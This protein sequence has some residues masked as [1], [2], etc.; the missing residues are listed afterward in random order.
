MSDVIV[1]EFQ[2]ADAEA[3][4][5]LNREW[6]QRHFWLEPADLEVL[7]HPQTAILDT[8][9]HIFMAVRERRLR[10]LLR[11]DRHG[12]RRVRT[13][14]D[15]RNAHG[16]PPRHRPPA[17]RCGYRKGGTPRRD[18]PLS[19]NQP[20]PDRRDL[21][22]RI[23]G[24]SSPAARPGEAIA[25]HS[26]Q[27]LHGAHDGAGDGCA[28]SLRGRPRTAIRLL[29]RFYRGNCFLNASMQPLPVAFCVMPPQPSCQKGN[30]PGP[31]PYP[32]KYARAVAP[33]EKLAP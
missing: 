14:Q 19:R 18:T 26:R 21:A 17:H 28:S 29:K 4:F 15:G 11:A 12:S 32:L 2:P 3:F 33:G 1:R 24:L 10:G 20:D 30:D 13:G 27:C 7:W 31:G 23:D 22:L 9:G 25:L 16:A 6:I 5:E 8:G